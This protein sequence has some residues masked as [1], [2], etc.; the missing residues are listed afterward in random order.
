[1]LEFLE[2]N[3][4]TVAAHG[5]RRLMDNVGRAADGKAGPF[6]HG[7]AVDVFLGVLCPL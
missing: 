1:M 4:H 2:K 5:M 6:L 3:A 7:S